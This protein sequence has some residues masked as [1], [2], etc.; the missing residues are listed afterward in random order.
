MLKNFIYLDCPNQ[1]II[2]KKSLDVLIQH[3]TLFTDFKGHNWR[4]PIVGFELVQFLTMV[5][6]L[7]EWARSLGLS[8]RAFWLLAYY[9]TSSIHIDDDVSPR[10]NFPLSHGS[11][12]V[13][14]FFKIRNLEI[15]EAFD[16]TVKF[17]H[18]IFKD[19][20]VTLIDS[21]KLTKPVVINPA[22]PHRVFFDTPLSAE[23][24][25]FAFSIS[26]HESLKPML[27]IK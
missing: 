14:E 5:P 23:N 17:Q 13:T 10:V 8:I 6:E 15:K 27:E 18:L 25:R 26:F 4:G 22:I 2:A 16:E 12:A 11:A 19:Q 9:K 7:E 24:P 1:E 21:Y 20:D 3:S